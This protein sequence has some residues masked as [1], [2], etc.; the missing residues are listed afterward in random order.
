M[1]QSPSDAKLSSDD[2]LFN[3]LGM[4]YEEFY[5]HNAGL[6]ENVRRLLDLLPASSARVLDCGC[7]TGKPVS[8]MIANRGHRVCGIDVSQTMVDLSRKQIPNGSFERADMLKYEAPADGFHGVVASL[9]LFKFEREEMTSMALKWFKWLQPGGL[10]LLVVVG[11]DDCATTPEMYDSDGECA[12]G[13]PWRFMNHNIPVTL[14]TKQGWN[15]L[16]TE[17]GFELVHSEINLF[18]PPTEAGCDDELQYFVIAR[19]HVTV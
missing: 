19:K 7:G 6:H 16:L 14:F 1:E 4:Q 13:I 12:R 17:A 2:A 15:K 9:S 11:A 8:H 5:G 3:Q 18:I 10:L